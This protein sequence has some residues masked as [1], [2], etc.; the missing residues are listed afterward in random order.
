MAY[1]QEQLLHYLDAH[2]ITYQLYTHPQLFTC[3]QALHIVK[4][5]NMPGQGIKNLFLK[6]SKKQLY[7]VVAVYSTRID[8]K[9][10]SKALQ[11]K[12]LRFADAALL[13]HHLGVEPGSV[14]PLALINDAQHAVHVIIDAE[15]FKQDLIQIHPL[16]N[17]ATVVIRPADFDLFLQSI[18]RSYIVYGFTV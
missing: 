16:K 13:M 7:L 4:E 11:A 2:H 8:L 18:N 14:T 3:E 9:R 15:V 6:D 5:L 17:D 10:L 12:D 1:T